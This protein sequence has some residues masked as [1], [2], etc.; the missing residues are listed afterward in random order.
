MREYIKYKI[1]HQ[2]EPTLPVEDWIISNV[3]RI[4]ATQLV[5]I[6]KMVPLTLEDKRVIIYQLQAFLRPTRGVFRGDKKYL[7]SWNSIRS[8]LIAEKVSLPQANM[9][10]L[11]RAE[12]LEIKPH[13]DISLWLAQNLF[14]FDEKELRVFVP[15]LNLSE[16]EHGRLLMPL[17][18]SVFRRMEDVSKMK[19]KDELLQYYHRTR[20]LLLK[21]YLDAVYHQI[22]K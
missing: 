1:W 18:T 9:P 5:P 8:D 21:F 19:M 6:Q 22:N 12:D 3:L 11:F 16:P 10:P 13:G 20:Y 15:E 7:D 14:C 2:I 4:D 17:L